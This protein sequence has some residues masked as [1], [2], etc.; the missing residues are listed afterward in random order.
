MYEN[1]QIFFVNF[2]SS[3]APKSRMHRIC[4]LHFKAH[5]IKQV[6]GNERTVLIH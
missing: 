1:F 6:N 2:V 5:M 4:S 3:C